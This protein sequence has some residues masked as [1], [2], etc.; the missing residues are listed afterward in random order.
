[1]TVAGLISLS[2]TFKTL[3]VA[4]NLTCQLVV[5]PGGSDAVG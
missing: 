1:M 2:V 4:A 3:G 5:L